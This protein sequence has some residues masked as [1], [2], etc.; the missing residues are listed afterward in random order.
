MKNNIFIYLK[1]PVDI[2]FNFE[3]IK[4][5]IF[6]LFLKKCLHYWTSDETVA[7]RA[8]WGSIAGRRV[9]GDGRGPGGTAV[10]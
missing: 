8:G 10:R 6:I 2:I 3:N 4:Y 7:L 1:F 9:N 5:Y